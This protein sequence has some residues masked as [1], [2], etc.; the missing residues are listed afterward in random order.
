MPNSAA[1]PAALLRLAETARKDKVFV[2]TRNTWGKFLAH[3]ALSLTIARICPGV[4]I[5]ARFCL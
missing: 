4:N 2:Q 1:V 5:D 3:K